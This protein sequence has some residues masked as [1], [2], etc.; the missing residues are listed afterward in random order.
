MTYMRWLITVSLAPALR[1][2]QT[3][4]LNIKR[5]EVPRW[6]S[7]LGPNTTQTSK[8]PDKQSWSHPGTPHDKNG[9]QTREVLTCNTD[10]TRK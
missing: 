8:T 2:W 9:E 6:L 3:D 4:R 5:R 1:N 7:L 10:D